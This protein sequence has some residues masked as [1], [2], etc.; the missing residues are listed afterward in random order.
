MAPVAP[1]W[2][3]N[4]L[5]DQWSVLASMFEC[6]CLVCG[7]SNIWFPELT[8]TGDTF[9]KLLDQLLSQILFCTQMVKHISTLLLFLRQSV[10]D[11]HPASILSC[12]GVHPRWCQICYPSPTRATIFTTPP[13]KLKQMILQRRRVKICYIYVPNT[14]YI[15]YFVPSISSQLP[16]RC[17]E[18]TT[19]LNSFG[20]CHGPVLRQLSAT[21][22]SPGRFCQYFCQLGL[23][24]TS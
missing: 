7:W 8:S 18:T 5:G 19:W 6:V 16:K 15:L 23:R 4:Y 17:Q 2:S 20:Q 3:N 1:D 14:C 22:P 21:S 11:M 24:F 12:S 9:L 13:K 10:Q